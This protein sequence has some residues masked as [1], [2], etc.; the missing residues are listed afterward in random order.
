MK[1]KLMNQKLTILK[2]NRNAGIPDWLSDSNFFSITRTA[3]E[4]SIVCDMSCIPSHLG[5]IG[6]WVA[7]KVVGPLD[8]TTVGILSNLS[9]I[10]AKEKISIFVIS[11]YDTD[12]ILVQKKDQQKAIEAL[13]KHNEFINS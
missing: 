4:M 8:F 3:D 6:T 13:R 10:L 12:Y 11:T 5:S 7:I 9:E 2:L 1:L